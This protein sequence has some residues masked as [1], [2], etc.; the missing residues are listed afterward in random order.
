MTIE[1]RQRFAASDH[2]GDARQRRQQPGKL[3]L[4]FEN[5]IGAAAGEER[6]VAHELQ[7]IAKTLLGVQQN[8]FAVER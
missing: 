6:R 5:D 7:R 4:D 1:T 8:G 2:R 3:G